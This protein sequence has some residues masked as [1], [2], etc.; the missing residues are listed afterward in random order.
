MAV[1]GW[2]PVLLLL[3]LM[4]M[5]MPHHVAGRKDRRRMLTN[6]AGREDGTMLTINEGCGPGRFSS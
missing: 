6:V 1:M 4:M 2:L 3:L 5:I